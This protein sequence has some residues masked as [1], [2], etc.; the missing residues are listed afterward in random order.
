MKTISLKSSLVAGLRKSYRAGRNEPGLLSLVNAAVLPIGLY[1]YEPLANPIS[2][3][4][5]AGV[6]AVEVFRGPSYIVAFGNDDKVYTLA[7]GQSD[8]AETEVTTFLN[9]DNPSATLSF[10]AGTNQWHFAAFNLGWIATNGACALYSIK[11]S[12]YLDTVTYPKCV[13]SFRGRMFWGGMARHW[14]R[15]NSKGYSLDM[16]GQELE[17]MT[18]SWVGWCS[19]QG[20]DILQHVFPER[21]VSSSAG[22]VADELL[23]NGDFSGGNTDWTPATTLN[24]W[25]YTT[26]PNRMVA[27]PASNGAAS[28]GPAS[29]AALTA[30]RYRIEVQLTVTSGYVTVSLVTAYGDPTVYVGD[31]TLSETGLHVLYAELPEGHPPTFLRVVGTSFVGTLHS[32]SMVE[33]EHFDVTTTWEEQARL[34]QSGFSPASDQG[35]VLCIK[36]LHDHVVVYGENFI[37]A[38]SP[39]SVPVP[40]F[41]KVS[42]AS[43]GVAGRRAVGGDLNKHLLC[44]VSGKLWQIDNQLQLQPVG[45][46]E[47]LQDAVAYGGLSKI[48]IGYDDNSD[49]FYV[50]YEDSGL[51][52]SYLLTDFGLS[53]IDA[54]V[55]H[56]VCGTRGTATWADTTGYATDGAGDTFELETDVLD[57]EEAGHKT[58]KKIQVFGDGVENIYACVLFRGG[59]DATFRRGLQFQLNRLGEAY[60]EQS[61]LSL[62]IALSA[63]DY[64]D[65]R[66]YDIEVTY[67]TNGRINSKSVMTRR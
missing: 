24:N 56:S 42:I 16:W 15:F 62:K 54:E 63:A 55:V 32:F 5:N 3:A 47:F 39:V 51:Y 25:T 49:R 29:F 48:A 66:I 45:Y 38:Y 40:T 43:F 23:A 20:R 17:A 46:E 67:E 61:G 27:N 8:W 35:T 14:L 52:Q 41:G 65:I 26:T 4:A 12:V 36:A 33:S 34:L 59:Y 50:T 18:D 1:P 7:D 22:R 64:Q 30:R 57:F 13:C 28:Y 53:R 2:I 31:R 6:P 37:A 44:D 10:D 58:I 21:A 9:P 60:P 11:G 19:I